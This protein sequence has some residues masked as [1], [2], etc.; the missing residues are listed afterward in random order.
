MHIKENGNNTALVVV[1]SGLRHYAIRDE[2]GEVLFDR[3]QAAL[4]ILALQSIVRTGE[5]P[6]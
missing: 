1:Q 5:V 3:E 6:E 2:D 4:L